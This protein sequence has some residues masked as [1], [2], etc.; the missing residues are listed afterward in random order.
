[1]KKIAILTDT[2][3]IAEQDITNGP[4]NI[5]YVPLNI[6]FGEQSF[7]EYYELK[8]ADFYTKCATDPNHPKSSQPAV[9]LIA[10][11]LEQL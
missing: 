6:I 4:D 2:T 5:Y 7:Q 10:Q 1:M 11:K 8:S 9:G 3:A